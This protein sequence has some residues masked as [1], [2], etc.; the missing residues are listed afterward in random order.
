MTER[1][2]TWSPDL[3]WYRITVKG[4]L[5]RSW[6]GHFLSLAIT[7]DPKRGE[8]VLK[9]MV[10]DQTALLGLLTRLHDMNL[11]ILRLVRR[12]AQGR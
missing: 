4:C 6:S 10:R 1:N 3:A 9:G 8:T 5:D 2:A 11:P 12:P 7:P